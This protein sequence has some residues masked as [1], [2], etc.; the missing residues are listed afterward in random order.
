MELG[1]M[2]AKCVLK[3]GNVVEESLCEGDIAK[4]G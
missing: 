3:L 4:G 1:I 2:L